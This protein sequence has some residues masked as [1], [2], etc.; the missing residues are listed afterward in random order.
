MFS[1]R[2]PMHPQNVMKNMTTPTTMRMTAGST[3][4][5]SRTVSVKEREER[6]R[7]PDYVCL[8]LA[9]PLGSRHASI[10]L[11]RIARNTGA[12]SAEWISPE[13]T[14]IIPSVG[15]YPRLQMK[16]DKKK[17]TT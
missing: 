11:L 17:K 16:Y 9:S 15:V 13:R 8:L 14:G 1:L 6:E 10:R 2:A 3:K 4:N 12:E 5:V 7:A